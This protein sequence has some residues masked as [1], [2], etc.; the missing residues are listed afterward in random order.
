[1]IPIK[2]PMG[3]V[4]LPYVCQ[5]GEEGHTWNQ[6]VIRITGQ[7]K[8]DETRERLARH[9][10]QSEIYYP[11]AMHQQECFFETK[12]AGFP[13]A[14]MLCSETLALPLGAA[15][16]LDKKGHGKIRK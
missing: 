7:G 6:F 14:E 13:L 9:G 3:K 11:R 15:D 12:S 1:M 16:F 8:R 10:I 5:S 4:F 2:H